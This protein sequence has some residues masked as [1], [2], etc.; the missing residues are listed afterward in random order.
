MLVTMAILAFIIIR[1]PLIYT[2]FVY[3][4]DRFLLHCIFCDVHI[5]VIW[6]TVSYLSLFLPFE[7]DHFMY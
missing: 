2:V 3:R 4:S 6:I 5:E 7:S 1:N